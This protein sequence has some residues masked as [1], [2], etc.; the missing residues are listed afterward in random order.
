MERLL[1]DARR[2]DLIEYLVPSLVCA[3]E[4]RRLAGD[5]EGARALLDEFADRT[6]DEPRTRTLFIPIVARAL[7][8]LGD[9]SAIER[10]IPPPELVRTP[11]HRHGV[12]TARAIQAEA[13]GR[14]ED[15][16]VRY[17]DAALRWDVMGFSLEQG[18]TR[19]GQ[20]RCLIALGRTADA[21]RPLLE[22]RL[23]FER[24]GASD[25][26]AEVEALQAAD[27]SIS[28]V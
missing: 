1:D 5:D 6:A 26:L 23:R 4:T 18:L 19:L 12:V 28:A 11:R 13:E 15:A 20:A 24:L 8:A 7:A 17:R 9:P 14:Y 25:P 2:L 10:L 22:A 27:D 16:L 21:D 3:A